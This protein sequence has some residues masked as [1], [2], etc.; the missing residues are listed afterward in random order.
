MNAAR[1]IALFQMKTKNENI[2]NYVPV[3]SVQQQRFL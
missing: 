1:V 3:F 2:T